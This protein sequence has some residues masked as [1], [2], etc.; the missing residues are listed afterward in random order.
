MSEENGEGATYQRDIPLTITRPEWLKRE[1]GKIKAGG[2]LT[3]RCVM[4]TVE[5]LQAGLCL[6]EVPPARINRQQDTCSPE[7]QADRRR[8]RREDNA[9]RKCRV[10]GHGLTKKQREELAQRGSQVETQARTIEI[11]ES[12]KDANA[13]TSSSPAGPDSS[14]LH[15]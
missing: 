8:L 4:A 6:G 1:V 5:R 14:T 7:C 10:C 11:P 2:D 9:R 3:L 15:G 12:G 13:D